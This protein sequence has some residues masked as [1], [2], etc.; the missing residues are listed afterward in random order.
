MGPKRTKNLQNPLKPATTSQI[1]AYK[2]QIF[3]GAP[4]CKQFNAKNL[5]QTTKWQLCNTNKFE[6][7][8][9]FLENLRPEFPKFNLKFQMSPNGSWN[10]DNVSALPFYTAQIHAI[11]HQPAKNTQSCT[12][13]NI[14]Y[15]HKIRRSIAHDS[16]T[17]ET[18]MQIKLYN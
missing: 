10:S 4:S 14:Q 9:G 1:L 18:N 16:C 6:G 8:L 12:K 3:V 17:L 13:S 15:T 7:V 2:Y 5:F 11:Q